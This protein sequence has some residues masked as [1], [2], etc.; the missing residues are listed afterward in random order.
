MRRNTY[1]LANWYL[2]IRE[3]RCDAHRSGYAWAIVHGPGLDHDLPLVD[4]QHV[5]VVDA[6]VIHLKQSTCKSDNAIASHR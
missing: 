2:P 6:K 5:L 3:V 1:D 4:A